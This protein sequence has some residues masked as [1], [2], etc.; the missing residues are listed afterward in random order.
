VHQYIDLILQGDELVEKQRV[1]SYLIV[2]E[3]VVKLKRMRDVED[4]IVS[5]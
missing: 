3:F 4:S 2:P 5:H 1:A